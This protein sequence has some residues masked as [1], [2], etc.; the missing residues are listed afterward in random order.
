MSRF[1][2]AFVILGLIATYGLC[3]VV[4]MLLAVTVWLGLGLY[5]VYD[6]SE[7][8][9]ANTNSPRSWGRPRSAA[10]RRAAASLQAAFFDPPSS[11]SRSRLFRRP[12]LHGR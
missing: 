5:A 12:G 11:K 9:A 6:I 4:A 1:A 2:V 3:V 7:E 10:S 8:I